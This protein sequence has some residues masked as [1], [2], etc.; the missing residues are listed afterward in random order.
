MN[1]ATAKKINFVMQLAKCISY[2]LSACYKLHDFM[3]EPK[4]AF[5]YSIV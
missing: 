3:I 4:D 1:K 5:N 2:T